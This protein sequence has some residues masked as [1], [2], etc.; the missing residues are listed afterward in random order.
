MGAHSKH[1]GV[2]IIKSVQERSLRSFITAQSNFPGVVSMDFGSSLG[3]SPWDIIFFSIRSSLYL[4]PSNFSAY[5]PKKVG[6]PKTF[7]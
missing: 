4:Q 6:A 2:A 1:W 5:D 3:S 7:F